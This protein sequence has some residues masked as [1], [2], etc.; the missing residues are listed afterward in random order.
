MLIDAIQD[1]VEI[2]DG[3]NLDSYVYLPC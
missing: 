2:F 3:K 1:I